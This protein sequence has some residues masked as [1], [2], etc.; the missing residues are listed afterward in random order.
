M[1]RLQDKTAVF[2]G[3]GSSVG[4]AACR[5]FL[6]EGARVVLVDIDQKYFD[7]TSQLRAQ[8]GEDRVTTF[9]GAC[10]Q[11]ADMDAA[12]KFAAE[13]FGKVDILLN[14]AGFHG[15]GWVD[16]ILPEQWDRAM[17]VTCTGSYRAILAAMP[18]MKAQKSGH[19]INFTS[20][21]GRGNRM[22]AI[23]YA[24]SKAACTALTR[25]FA[26]EL[27]PYGI[28][29]TAYAPGTL[30]TKRFERIAEKG[31]IPRKMPPGGV[32]GMPGYQGPDLYNGQSVIRDRP[33]ASLDE[34]AA[35]LVYLASGES[36]YLT[37]DCLDM[38]GG[39]LMAT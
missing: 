37:A 8:Y 2:I 15:A 28:T 1:N 16:E 13:K 22:V 7:R 23:S 18:Y 38:N 19:I 25:A 5:T 39:I 4:S 30:D 3:G 20:L 33:V 9:L 36:R 26:M 14:I 21:G 17:D 35:A 24:G 27:A 6:E 31:S 12:L 34:V 11:Q 10:T 29:V 32:P